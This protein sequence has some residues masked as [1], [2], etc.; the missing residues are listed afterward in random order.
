M[1][2]MPDLA[3]AKTLRGSELLE[4]ISASLLYE[5]ARIR[6]IEI[7]LRPAGWDEQRASAHNALCAAVAIIDGIIAAG[8]KAAAK[9]ER[10]PG[11]VMAAVEAAR[12]SLI[13]EIT[14]QAIV[15]SAEIKES[16][17][18]AVA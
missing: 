18:A 17:D 3:V 2:L 8:A 1:A 6:S 15:A 4:A 16:S 12:E 13:V 10:P 5:A 14:T 11:Y 9:K 7:A